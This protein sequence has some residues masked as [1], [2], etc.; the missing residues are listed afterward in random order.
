MLTVNCDEPNAT[1]GDISFSLRSTAKGAVFG[2][3]V[4]SADEHSV[5]IQFTTTIQLA[6]KN[7]R[8]AF[9]FEKEGK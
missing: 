6:T 4:A 7:V 2:L 5:K 9:I 1:F 8:P 3:D